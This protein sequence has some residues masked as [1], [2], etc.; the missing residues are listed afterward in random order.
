VIKFSPSEIALSL[1]ALSCWASN[2][3]VD[4]LIDLAEFRPVSE[5]LPS[6]IDSAKRYGPEVFGSIWSAFVYSFGFIPTI[7]LHQRHRLVGQ[8]KCLVFSSAQI[9]LRMHRQMPRT[10]AHRK[11]DAEALAPFRHCPGEELRQ[12]CLDR[13]LSF[14]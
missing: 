5:S 1:C 7:D 6:A 8:S 3:H 10:D 12:Y 9:P 2:D 14:P 11:S 13:E 4:S